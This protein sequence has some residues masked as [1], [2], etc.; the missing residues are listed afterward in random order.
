MRRPARGPHGRVGRIRLAR[1]VEVGLEE[2]ELRDRHRSPDPV[3]GGVDGRRD[4]GRRV[5]ARDADLCRDEQRLRSH[6]QRAQVN[7]PVHLGGTL[8]R[9]DDLA[10]RLRAPPVAAMVD[11][12]CF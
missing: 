3:L 2:D 8:D 10:L 12:F 7:D 9:S 6:M 1:P 11:E 4:P 5:A